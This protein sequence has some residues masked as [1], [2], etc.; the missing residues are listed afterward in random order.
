MDGFAWGNPGEAACG[1]DFRELIGLLKGA[2]L[3]LGIIKQHFMLKN[4]CI[5]VAIEEATSR[6]W[7][8]VWLESDSVIRSVYLV[9]IIQL[10]LL[11][12]A[13]VIDGLTIAVWL[14]KY[15]F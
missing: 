15:G 13:L 5:T 9:L 12:D 7:H 2:L 6:G 1:E 8:Y 10:S 4:F 3:C 14:K 11:H